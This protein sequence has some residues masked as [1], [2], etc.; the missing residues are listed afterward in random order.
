MNTN[1]LQ[2][3]LPLVP[4]KRRPIPLDEQTLFAK[5]SFLAALRYVI[6][7]GNFEYEKECYQALGIDAGNWSR[8]MNGSASFPQDKEDSLEELCGNIGLTLW[9]ANRKGYKLIPLE[10]AKDKEIAR[11]RA[12]AEEAEMKYQAAIEFMRRIKE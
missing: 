6:Q 7:C 8:I 1:L 5:P 11:Q 12:R 10:D 3:E 9:R 4:P 2:T